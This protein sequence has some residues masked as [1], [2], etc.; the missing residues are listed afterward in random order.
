MLI[1]M[2][3]DTSVFQFIGAT[4]IIFRTQSLENTYYQP[5]V[6]YTAAGA[7]YVLATFVIDYLFRNVARAMTVPPS[8]GLAGTLGRRRRRQINAVVERVEG[9][10]VGS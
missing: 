7:V 6:L 3:K 1:G 9:V 10:A 5:F 8:G 4:E 2:I